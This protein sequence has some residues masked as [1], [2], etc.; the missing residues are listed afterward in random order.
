MPPQESLQ[1]D[2]VASVAEEAGKCRFDGKG[3][4]VGDAVGAE[5]LH[6]AFGAA[7]LAMASFADDTL[8]YCTWLCT[9]DSCGDAVARPHSDAHCK[10][11]VGNAQAVPGLQ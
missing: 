11:L 1:I 3:D 9:R 5:A 10:I 2:D 6:A 4:A 7:R 8:M